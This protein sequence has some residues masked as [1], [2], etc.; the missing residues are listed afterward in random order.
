MIKCQGTEPAMTAYLVTGHAGAIEWAARQG[1]E[2]IHVP[3]LDPA[4]IRAGDVV[5]GTLPVH[6]IAEI[7][8][9][10]AR[11]LHLA[12][13]LPKEARQR[14]LS[15]DEMEAFGARLEEYKARRVQ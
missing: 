6:L 2:A 14:N 9:R 12:L 1:I 3:H 11:Y 10:G 4:A 7:N 5:I 15:A 8:A 13:D